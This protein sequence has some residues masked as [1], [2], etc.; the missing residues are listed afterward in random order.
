[1]IDVTDEDIGKNIIHGIENPE[2]DKSYGKIVKLD[3]EFVYCR[4]RSSNKV[5]PCKREDL[6]WDFP[7]DW[8][9]ETGTDLDWNNYMKKSKKK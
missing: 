9:G 4:L 7:D 1:M 6:D 5:V 8:D 3:E 2:L